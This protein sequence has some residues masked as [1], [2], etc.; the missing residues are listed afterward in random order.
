M[1]VFLVALRNELRIDEEE[2]RGVRVGVLDFL[3]LQVRLA[4]FGLF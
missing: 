4:F 1:G 3:L 2:G